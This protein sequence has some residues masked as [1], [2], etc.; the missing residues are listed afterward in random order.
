MCLIYRKV[1]RHI[2][3]QNE[4]MMLIVMGDHGMTRSGKLLVE[5]IY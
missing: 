5:T 1:V 2:D 3:D 4:N